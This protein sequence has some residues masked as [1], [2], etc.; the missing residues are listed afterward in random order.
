MSVILSFEYETSVD[1][2]LVTEEQFPTTLHHFTGSKDHNIK[3]RQ[4]AKERGERISEYGVETVETG[5]IKT[6]PSEREFYAHFGLPLIPPELR[7]SGQ[8]VETYSNSIELI[9]PEQIKEISTCTQ[10]GAM[11]RFLSERWLKHAWKK[12]I[13]IWRSPITRNI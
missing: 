13:N 7:E 8:E 3:M 9:E 11:G 1:F 10:R 5:D 6:F 12:A 2:R 4:I